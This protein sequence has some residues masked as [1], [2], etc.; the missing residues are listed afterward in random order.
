MPANGV[1]TAEWVALTLAALVALLVP[2]LAAADVDSPIRAALAVL[3]AFLVP[4]V[5]ISLLL[6]LDPEQQLIAAPAVSLSALAVVSVAFLLGH[7]WHPLGIQ[8]VLSA[9]G[10]VATVPAAGLVRG[11][12]RSSRAP[13]IAA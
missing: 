10:L 3:S 9:I 5:P 7:A 6:R 13:R 2:V 8:I 1:V 4:G 12:S 11:R